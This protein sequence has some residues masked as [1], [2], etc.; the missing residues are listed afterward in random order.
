MPVFPC[1]EWKSPLTENGYLD[2]TVRVP[3]VRRWWARREDALIAIPT[4]RVSNLVV[5]DVDGDDGRDALH[6]LERRYGPLPVTAIATTPGG[7]EHYYFRHPGVEVRCSVSKI[8]R[9]LDVR[10]DGGYAI[11]PPSRLPDGRRYEFDRRGM[12]APVPA[13]LLGLM[14]AS[15]GSGRRTDPS[16]WAQIVRDGLDEGERNNQLARLAGHLLRKD[17]HI[18]LVLELMLLVN[19]RCRPEPL[20]ADEVGRIVTSIAGA[21]TRRRQRTAA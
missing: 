5:L 4:G 8:G 3:Q 18:D 2:A 15:V 20:P 7:G 16:G 11:V 1:D 13:W 9:H 14:T 6:D 19:T 21:E 10:G 12:V 17:L